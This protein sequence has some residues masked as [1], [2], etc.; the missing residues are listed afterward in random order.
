MVIVTLAPLL[1]L[2][3]AA[4]VYHLADEEDEPEEDGP[5]DEF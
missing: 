3:L 5:E 1:V 2:V 4:V